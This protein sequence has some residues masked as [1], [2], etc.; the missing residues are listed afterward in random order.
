MGYG[1]GVNELK[2]YQNGSKLSL[3]ESVIA[4]C[5]EC[6]NFYMDGRIDCG[7]KE[8]PLYPWMPYGVLWRYREKRIFSGRCGFTVSSR[9]RRGVL[10][11]D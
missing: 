11:T 2:K 4:K 10:E 1:K 5:A 7:I 8:C 9:K 3:K 6:M